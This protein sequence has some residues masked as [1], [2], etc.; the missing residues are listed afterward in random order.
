MEA[1]A[2]AQVLAKL[3]SDL[4]GRFKTVRAEE[5]NLGNLLA[6]VAMAAL[7]V[8]EPRIVLVQVWFSCICQFATLWLWSAS[9]FP[10]RLKS[11]L[12]TI[13]LQPCSVLRQKVGITVYKRD[14]RTFCFFTL[15]P[16]DHHQLDVSHISS[17]WKW[18]QIV[19]KRS[20]PMQ[21]QCPCCT[22][23][24]WSDRYIYATHPH[25]RGFVG[26]QRPKT[27]TMFFGPTVQTR[28]LRQPRPVAA[29]AAGQNIQFSSKF[30]WGHW[31]SKESWGIVV[32]ATAG[33]WCLDVVWGWCIVSYHITS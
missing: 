21:C 22:P 4:D 8:S 26:R 32:A 33:M 9:R 23:D 18:F 19:D 29:A 30:G 6:D 25:R 15:S 28:R 17:R 27:L 10:Q 5:A 31:K 20:M 24:I 12:A 14:I 2:G 13:S 16:S 11:L 3:G 1:E 7:Q